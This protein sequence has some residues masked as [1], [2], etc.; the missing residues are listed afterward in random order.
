MNKAIILGLVMAFATGAAQ[1]AGDA[2]AG[3]AKAAACAGCHGTDGNSPAPN[4]PKLAGQHPSYIIKQLQEFK[5]GARKDTTNMM[6]PMVAGL[7]EQDMAD[8]AAFF[9]SQ[10]DSGGS[11]DAALVNAGEQIY[12]AGNSDKGLPSCMGCHGPNGAGNGASRF[13]NLS[14]QHATYSTKQ[15]QD[16]RSGERANDPQL[17]MRNIAARM[18][19]AEINAVASYLNGLR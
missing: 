15:L 19:D 9:A 8:L 17:M 18:S 16:F 4:F 6:A 11:A 2:A 7:S 3:Q 13:P 5:S 1:A 12:R 14:G 10:E